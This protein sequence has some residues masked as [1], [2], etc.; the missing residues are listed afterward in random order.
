MGLVS[1]AELVRLGV[2]VRASFFRFYF[3]L[4]SW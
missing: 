4:L 2:L 3:V 1:S